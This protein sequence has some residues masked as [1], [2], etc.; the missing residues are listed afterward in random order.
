MGKELDALIAN[1]AATLT[2]TAGY[3]GS[4][5]LRST[6]GPERTWEGAMAEYVRRLWHTDIKEEMRRWT[7]EVGSLTEPFTVM[8]REAVN[9]FFRSLS[10]TD[11]DPAAL[12]VLPVETD[13]SGPRSQRPVEQPPQASVDAAWVALV[14]LSLP[15]I[16]RDDRTA[17]REGGVR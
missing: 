11:S 10:P 1:T 16:W 3:G 9:E 7:S 8:W 6:D 13:K 15:M 5:D 12:P 14:A 17:A 4:E 2:A